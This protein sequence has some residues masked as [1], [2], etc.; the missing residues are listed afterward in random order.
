[1]YIIQ[2]KTELDIQYINKKIQE[3][4]QEVGRLP[5]SLR[6]LVTHG[7][8]DSIPAEPHGERFV[9]RDG[10]AQ[11]TWRRDKSRAQ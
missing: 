3:F 10:K 11:T 1:M 8:L 6:E 7:Y 9:I 4:T 5:V 2:I